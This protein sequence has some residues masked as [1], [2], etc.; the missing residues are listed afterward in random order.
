[1]LMLL[2]EYTM[3][4]INEKVKIGDRY[5]IIT[6]VFEPN[7]YHSGRF[8][9]H[10]HEKNYEHDSEFWFTDYGTSVVPIQKL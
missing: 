5:G 1:M 9:V 10:I 7:E 2:K 3:P 4:R 6:K 8:I